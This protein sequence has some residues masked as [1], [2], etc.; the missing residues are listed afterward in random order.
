MTNAKSL[1][2]LVHKAPINHDLL[3]R[4]R[5]RVPSVRPDIESPLLGILSFQD[6]QTPP[7]LLPYAQ[8]VAGVPPSPGLGPAFSP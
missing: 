1:H 8:S 6:L 7:T 4:A 5:P 2:S 3:P